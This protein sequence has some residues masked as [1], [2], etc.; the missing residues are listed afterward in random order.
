M[1]NTS[2]FWEVLGATTA[3]SPPQ[4]PVQAALYASYS[5]IGLSMRGFGFDPNDLT[6]GVI[7]GMEMGLAAGLTCVIGAA[8]TAQAAARTPTLWQPVSGAL[9]YGH[10]CESLHHHPDKSHS[11]SLT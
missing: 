2:A 10:N 5:G 1:Q 6:D 9:S 4:D 7:L 11:L 8:Q 3:L